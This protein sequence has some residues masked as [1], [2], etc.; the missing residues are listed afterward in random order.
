LK[1]PA[2]LEPVLKALRAV[3][4]PRIV[5]GAVRDW[6]LGREAKDLDI[7]VAGASFGAL[8]R[9]LSP[10]GATDVVGRSFGVIKLRLSTGTEYDISLPR[11]ESKTGAGHRGFRVEPDPT[12]NDA[13][14][15]ARR[16]FTINALAWDPAENRLVDP[17]GGESDLRARRLRHVGP[18]FVEDPLRVLRAMQFAARFDLT[19]DPD[20]AALCRSIAPTF[21]ELPVERIWHEWSKWAEKSAT[22]SRGLTVLAETGW[23][24]HFPELASLAACQQDP[25]WHPEGDVFTHTGHCCDALARDPEWQAADPRRRRLLMLAVLLHDVGKPS[26]TRREEKPP[27]SGRLR[28]TSPGHEAA[29]VALAE[30]FLR[31]IGSPL[32]HAP[33]VAP[34]VANHMVHLHGGE[35]GPGPNAIRRLARR[36]APAT[37]A[38]LAAVMRADA[39]GRPPLPGADSL[40]LIARLLS[41]AGELALA[42]AAPRPLL[43]GRHLIAAGLR[44]GPA[45]KSLL[46]AAFEA[47]LDGAFADEAGALLWLK[48]QFPKTSAPDA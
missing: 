42:D 41:R 39:L 34:L 38:D 12:L 48:N 7:E 46:D 29:G 2:E 6:L 20:T 23:L 36:L 43:L 10:L 47:Q 18:A 8:E 37:L 19:L 44:P 11:R 15:A 16:D 14:A 33:A 5:G 32:D 28:W 35:D 40:P 27:A 22:P 9:V 45:F 17:H 31:R 13:E 30:S 24:A 1:L 3:G 4:R 25:E 26:C 21:A